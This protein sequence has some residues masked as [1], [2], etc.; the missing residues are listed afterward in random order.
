VLRKRKRD[1]KQ[2]LKNEISDV[3]D[4]RK[5]INLDKK[6][7]K[8]EYRTSLD[9]NDYLMTLSMPKVNVVHENLRCRSIESER[10]NSNCS[11]LST[12]N[13]RRSCKHG[14]NVGNEKIILSLEKGFLE[15]ILDRL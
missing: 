1:L 12:E 15:F 14:Y 9:E 7:L 4:V 13:V 11:I 5:D 3:R 10:G 2:V 8:Q 6:A